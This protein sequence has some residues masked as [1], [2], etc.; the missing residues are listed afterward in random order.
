MKTKL[1]ILFM[2]VSILSFGQKSPKESAQGTVNDVK[3]SIDYSSP[4]VKGRAIFGNLV[5]YGDVWRAGANTNTTIEFSKNVSINGL[6]LPAGKYGFFVIPNEN[7]AWVAIFNK[8][9]NNWGAFS[10][11]ES[12]DALRVKVKVKKTDTSVE[13]L[14]YK[15]TE[16]GVLFSWA[17]SSFTLNISE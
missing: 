17:D 14:T 6:K 9:N 16:N 4:R 3:I 12:D 8:K 11:S 7:D 13:N 2:L 10:Y 15:V 5:P 1:L